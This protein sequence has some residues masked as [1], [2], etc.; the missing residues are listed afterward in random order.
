VSE[1][2]S[3]SPNSQ[4][5]VVGGGVAGL[6]AVQALRRHG[7]KGRV[8]LLC[9]EDR[10]PYDRPPLSKQYLSGSWPSEKLEL[11]TRDAVESLNSRIL[12]A[13]AAIAISVENRFVVDAE[14]QKHQFDVC[15]I[16]TGV[17]PR[18]LLGDALGFVHVLRTLGDATHLRAE[19]SSARSLVVVGGGFLGLEVA[20]TATQMGVKTT[21][22]ESLKVPLANRLG[23]L[24]A[25]RLLDLHGQHGVEVLT[26]VGVVSLGHIKGPSGSGIPGPSSGGR[27]DRVVHL[28]DGTELAADVV[29]VAVGTEPSTEWLAGSEVPVDNGVVCNAYCQAAP[30]VWAAGDVARWYHPNLGQHVRFE[31]RM[32]ASEQGQFVGMTIMGARKPFRP[33][34]YFWT[35]QFDVRIQ[36]AG[37]APDDATTEVVET[38]NSR[39]G[40]IVT[41]CRNRRLV[42]T[43]A[44][45]AA[46]EMLPY[47]RQL[48]VATSSEQIR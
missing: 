25:Q 11:A 32:N 38:G 36:L 10:V 46:R 24:A 4:V 3:G 14:G 29:V 5:V 39:G 44:W 30:G 2:S 7:W 40:F 33:V 23:L 41:F 19:L 43:L 15:V 31:H 20:A 22:V 45:N 21:V 16:A 47:R 48:E 17:R 26:G 1:Q 9:A 18:R 6:S 8:R 27:E 37:F 12:M 34:P 42:G 35:D 28:D 13:T